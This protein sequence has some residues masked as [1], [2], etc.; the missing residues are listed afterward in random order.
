MSMK[1]AAYLLA[2]ACALVACQSP[3]SPAPVLEH[4]SN[5]KPPEPKRPL[6]PPPVAPKVVDRAADAPGYYTVKK[7]DTL[8]RVALDHGQNYRDLVTWNHLSNPNDI[9]IDQVLRVSPPDAGASANGVQIEKVSA[10]PA[11]DRNPKPAAS[12]NASN[13][14]G[15]GNA[16]AVV[17]KSSPRGDKRPYSEATLAELQKSDASSNTAAAAASASAAVATAPASPAAASNPPV[18]E[19]ALSWIW[20]TDGRILAGFEE[21]KN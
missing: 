9:K 3:Q 5:V 6:A 20:P 7:G 15:A 1:S 2:A 8:I 4:S 11:L 18:T 10:A 21:G 17:N 14:A 19:E 12:T 13:N 16:V